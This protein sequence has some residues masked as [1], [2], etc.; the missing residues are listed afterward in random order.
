MKNLW[1]AGTLTVIFSSFGAYATFDGI[2]AH[3]PIRGNSRP[4]C[5][6]VPS[7]FTNVLKLSGFADPTR[8]G[9]HD[10]GSFVRKKKMAPPAGFE[11]E[12]FGSLYSCRGGF[13]DLSH[14]RDNADWAASIYRALLENLG[15]GVTVPIHK[16]G[17]SEA[18]S[19]VLPALSADRMAAMTPEKIR[20]MAVALAFDLGEFHEIATSFTM[21]VSGPPIFIIGDYIVNE[22]SSAF[23]VEDAYSNLLG[24]YLGVEAAASALPYNSAMTKLLAERMAEIG[25]LKPEGTKDVF[26]SLKRIWWKPGMPTSRQPRKRNFQYEGVMTPKLPVGKAVTARCGETSVPHTLEIP[27]VSSVTGFP[28]QEVAYVRIKADRKFL[29][30]MAKIGAKADANGYVTR[31]QFDQIIPRIHDFWE[32]K[33]PE[34]DEFPTE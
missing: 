24:G 10:F 6:F 18:T 14:V 29:R 28:D 11:R 20:R 9:T 3:H 7:P 21:A 17:G 13:I 31:A 27:T 2:P 26:E 4:C 34:L 1:L 15:R 33:I 19:L 23:S 30:K 16:E 5:N 8:L 12:V 22:R 25:A 32:T